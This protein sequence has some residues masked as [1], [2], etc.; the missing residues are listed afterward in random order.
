MD[1]KEQN[2]DKSGS[3]HVDAKL[4]WIESE[5]EEITNEIEECRFQ[6]EFYDS[7]DEP[8]TYYEKLGFLYYRKTF[9]EQLYYAMK[10]ASE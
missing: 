5:I 4:R 7:N 3:F 10:E 9:L 6:T 2:D 8:C 1:N